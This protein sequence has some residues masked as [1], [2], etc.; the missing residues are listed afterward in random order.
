V[1]IQST[2]STAFFRL[3]LPRLAEGCGVTRPLDVVVL[4]LDAMM[5][6]KRERQAGVNAFY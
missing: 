2:F 5:E 3:V 6:L 4:D 1:L